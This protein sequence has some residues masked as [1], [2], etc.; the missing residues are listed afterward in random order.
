[1]SDCDKDERNTCRSHVS[2]GVSV[3]LLAFAVFGWGLHSKLSVYHLRKSASAVAPIAKL[4]SERERPAAAAQYCDVNCSELHTAALAATPILLPRLV[5]ENQ[6][7]RSRNDVP[8]LLW[9]TVGFNGPSLRRPP[10][11]LFA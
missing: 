1:M 6:P 10:P 8:P 5:T 7:L 2:I 9:R 11:F 3:F 4:L